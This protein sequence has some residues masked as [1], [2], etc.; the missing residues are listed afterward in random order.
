MIAEL[1]DG[2]IVPSDPCR[3][4][5]GQL[6]RH[7][8]RDRRRAR[9][10][11]RLGRR[12]SRACHRSRFSRGRRA[13]T[14]SRGRDQRRSRRVVRAAVRCRDLAAAPP[15]S[16]LPP[17]TAAAAISA[18]L[19][20]GSGAAAIDRGARLGRGPRS[21][22]VGGLRSALPRTAARPRPPS[23]SMREPPT[24]ARW[25][26]RDGDPALDQ[27]RA[28]GAPAFRDDLDAVMAVMSAAFGSRYGEAW[29]RSQCAGILPMA[30]VS[31]TLARDADSGRRVG[32]SLARSGRRRGRAAAA[33][34][35]FRAI[36]GRVSAA[37]L[38]DDFIDTRARRRREPRAS[39]SSR[40]QPSDRDVSST[41][42]SPR[43]AGAATI[44]V[45]ATA[46]ASTL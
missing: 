38:L 41:P 8:R 17:P 23:R 33:R 46:T 5:S 15:Y 44:T 3:R 20:V 10:G 30:G 6:H 26:P 21:L 39:R 25:S 16:N 13:G 32:F 14:G 36:T 35:R 19:V 1:L 40:R 7:S 37:R 18:Q 22:A 45:A 12:R 42:A 31:L 29:T 43:S 28:A 34:R 2:R 24:H 27:S 9:A 11:H 4:R